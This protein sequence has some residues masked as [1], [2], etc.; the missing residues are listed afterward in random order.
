MSRLNRRGRPCVSLIAVVS[1][2][3]L[4]AVA[5][6]KSTTSPESTLSS[7]VVS[8]YCGA[9]VTA[10]MDGAEKATIENSAE[11]TINNVAAGSRLIEAKKADSGLLVLTTTLDVKASTTIYVSVTGGA[12]VRV[13]N[14]YGEI[15][16]IYGDD[17]YVGDIG[18]QI[19]QT[20]LKVTF[21]THVFQAKKKS[22]GT[23]VSE[24]SIDVADLSEYTWTITP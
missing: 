16:S 19:T 14:Q 3:L 1:G 10:Y 11:F 18:N 24:L 22:D 17:A 12:S 23:V 20:I 4:M 15:L 13:T 9:A 2:M 8:N 7:I 5:G 6:C 21:G